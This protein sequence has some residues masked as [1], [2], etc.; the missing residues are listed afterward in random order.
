M[1]NIIKG[2]CIVIRT[3]WKCFLRVL[4]WLL[5]IVWFSYYQVLFSIVD[6]NKTFEDVYSDTLCTIATL[7]LNISILVV[8]L[9]DYVYKRKKNTRIGPMV[10]WTMLLGLICVMS[11]WPLTETYC[12]GEFRGFSCKMSFN[13]GY[14][15]HLLFFVDVF[16]IKYLTERKTLKK[17]GRRV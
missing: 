4:I 7:V 11:I 1:D 14:I 6:N 10:L 15:P 8:A 13:W 9:F 17:F 3:Q 2:V 12:C 16:I 5:I